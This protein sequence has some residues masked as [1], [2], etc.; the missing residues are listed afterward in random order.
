MHIV[1]RSHTLAALVAALFCVPWSPARAHASAGAP[2]AMDP[3]PQIVAPM[4]R[5]LLA[6]FPWDAR[7]RRRSAV[8]KVAAPV[9]GTRRA[10]WAQNSRTRR[11]YQVQATCRVVGVHSY[12]FVDDT[13]WGGRVRQDEVDAISRAFDAAT[14]GHPDRGIYDIETQAFGP[15]PDVDGDPRVYFLIMDIQDSFSGTGSYIAGYFSGINEF[16]DIEARRRGF[17]SNE[18][19]MFYLDCNPLD[20][21][22]SAAHSV[23]AHE[24]QH[25]IHFGAD[26]QEE[27]WLTEGCSTFSEL[28]TGYGARQPY[29]FSKLSGDGLVQWASSQLDYEQT[30]MF[31]TYL[32]EHYGGL[33]TIRALIADTTNGTDSVD[34]TVRPLGTNFGGVFEEWVIANYIDDSGLLG[35]EYGYESYVLSGDS[36]FLDSAVHAQHPLPVTRSSVYYSATRYIRFEHVRDL[37]IH[38]AGSE[39]NTF[40]LQYIGLAQGAPVEVGE[41]P[42]NERNEGYRDFR[43]DTLD[44]VVLVPAVLEPTFLTVSFSYSTCDLPTG[45]NVGGLHPGIAHASPLPGAEGVSLFKVLSLTFNRAYDPETLLLDTGDYPAGEIARSQDG[46]SL[47]VTPTG[48]LEPDKTYTVTVRAGVRDTQGALMVDTD[49]AWR[50]TTASADQ[51]IELAYDSEDFTRQLTWEEEGQGSGVRFTPPM[52]PHCSPP[53]ISICSA[54]TTAAASSC[55][56][57]QT[58]GT[59]RPTSPLTCWTRR[60]WSPRSK[61]GGSIWT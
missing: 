17:R 37:S 48:R 8:A 39:G 53:P 52:C 1:A 33:G 30:G 23:V 25:M 56:C 31:V 12:I 6:E 29:A 54:W 60:S 38:F 18:V 58:R 5:D 14:P 10:F 40:A 34:N 51:P 16:T 35:G 46:Q 45:P 47:T 36:Q 19:E 2:Q 20:V 32:Y 49:F 26:P 28:L 27:T 9:V 15:T 57:S 7:S 55:A 44:T 24:F 59:A 50:F 21:R 22:S 11:F 4:E 3:R 42:L 13:Q 41:I 61:P 43:G